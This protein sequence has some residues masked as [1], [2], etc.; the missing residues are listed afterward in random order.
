MTE[1]DVESGES[2]GDDGSVA[3]ALGLTDVRTEVRE[4]E[5]DGVLDDDGE[6]HAGTVGSWDGGNLRGKK[7]SKCVA[8]EK[9]GRN[10]SHNDGSG[11]IREMLIREDRRTTVE[12]RTDPAEEVRRSFLL[13]ILESFPDGTK[14]RLGRFL[15]RTTSGSV[16]TRARVDGDDDLLGARD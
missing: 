5:D 13:L 9:G 2:V 7:R 12:S 16:G 6:G 10:E 4:L 15:R 1:E 11:I 3:D 8:W 14:K